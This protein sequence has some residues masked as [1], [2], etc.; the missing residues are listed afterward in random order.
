MQRAQSNSNRRVWLVAG[1]RT[2]CGMH[3]FTVQ[4]P[5]DLQIA[6]VG[7]VGRDPISGGAM[8]E[9]VQYEKRIVAIKNVTIVVMVSVYGE[10]VRH[11]GILILAENGISHLDS[12]ST[13]TR[14]RPLIRGRLI[15]LCST[16]SRIL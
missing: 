11:R 4:V 3:P 1:H 7:P 9:R 8:D 12:T 13:T 16:T 15:R 6:G 2:R 10:A 14:Y 5:S